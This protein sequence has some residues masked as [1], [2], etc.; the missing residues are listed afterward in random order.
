MSGMAVV[1]MLYRNDGQDNSPIGS[2][3]KDVKMVTD[4]QLFVC[5]VFC[6]FCFVFRKSMSDRGMKYKD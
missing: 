2:D 5:F 4:C 3:S 6:L 1:T